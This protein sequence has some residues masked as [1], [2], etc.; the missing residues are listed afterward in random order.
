MQAYFLNFVLKADERLNLRKCFRI[1]L[2]FTTRVLSTVILSFKCHPYLIKC[3]NHPLLRLNTD[4]ILIAQ[5]TAFEKAIF[6]D[7]RR[8]LF[9]Y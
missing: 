9:Y 6:Y 7:Y 3:T 5:T 2:R 1:F 4:I 8:N